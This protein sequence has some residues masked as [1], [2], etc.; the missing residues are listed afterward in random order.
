MANINWTRLL[1]ILLTVLVAVALVSFALWIVFHFIAELLLLFLAAVLAYLLAPVVENVRRVT[2]LPRAICTA[3]IYV[4]VVLVV[5]RLGSLAAPPIVAQTRAF[6]LRL[7]AL[8]RQFDVQSAD[9]EQALRSHGIALPVSGVA[10]N[11][12]TAIG[13]AGPI[14]LS[15]VLSF[16]TSV[17]NVLF[18]AGVVLVM[19]FYLVTDSDSIGHALGAVVPARYAPGATFAARSAGN[20]IGRYVRAQL[21]VAL[22][23]A[24]LG[25]AGA[26]VLGVQYAPLIGIFAFFAESIPFLGPIIATVPAVLLT[27]VDSPWKA[28]AV[29]LWFVIV[30]QLEQSVIMP[31]LSGHAVGI[32]PVAAIMAVLIGFDLGS[33]W[34][35]LL[36]V[37]IL[38]YAVAL[39]REA[40]RVYARTAETPPPAPQQAQP[41]AVAGR[42]G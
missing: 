28:L 5:V 16:V 25:G 1:I 7:P 22:M 29:L 3:L 6:Q 30:Q 38:G 40:W 34:G 42:S 27:L 13:G 39:A 36:A 11:A 32:H 21:A 12:A 9:L 31:R 8:L 17:G 10:G 19:A 2:R 26:A 14:V 24:I 18:D 41:E 35:A 23:V 4:V 15:N 37:P 20:I 33:F